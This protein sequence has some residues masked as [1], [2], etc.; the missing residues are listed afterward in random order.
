[1]SDTP[2]VLKTILKRKAEEVAERSSKI[3]LRRLSQQAAASPEPVGFTEAIDARMV[4]QQPAIIAEIKRASPSK[5]VIREQFYPAEIAESYERGGATCLSVLT[6]EY[7]FHGS[8]KYLQQVRA[9]CMLPILRKDFVI[10]P[11]QIYESRAIGADCILLI[12]AALGDAKLHE[13][14]S[15]AGHLGMDILVEVHNEE[16]LRRAL[17]LNTRLIG[18]NNRDLRTFKTDINT[19]LRLIPLIPKRHIIV[20]ESG[21]NTSK[22]VATLRKSGVHAFLIGE[23]FMRAEDPG[24][25]LEELFS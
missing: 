18:I 1:M 10:D 19:T 24:S 9:A 20:S 13:L 22:E 11:Y 21:I 3:S 15:L 7:F 17:P 23:A 2:D 16:E 6:D 25:A 4:F 12:V 8:D 14:A 5:G